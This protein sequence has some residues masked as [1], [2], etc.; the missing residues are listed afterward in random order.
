MTSSQP[1]QFDPQPIMRRAI[2]LAKKAQFQTDP[3]PM[4]GAILVDQSGT[5]LAE[6]YH[7]KA[8]S[9]HAEVETLKSFKKTPKGSV[10]FV[11]LEPCNI[12]GKTPPC[13]DLILDKQV[14]TVIVGCKDPNPKVAGRGIQKL[15]E[16]GVEVIVGVCEQEC[17][18]MNRVFNKHIVKKLPYVTIK[19]AMSL[20]GKIAMASGES[21]WITGCEARKDGQRLRSQHMA[22]AVGNK[23][24]FADNPRLTDRVSESPRQPARVVFSSKGNIPSDSHFL[25]RTETQRIVI[26]GANIAPEVRTQLQQA[27]V[28]LIVENNEFP[29]IPSSLAELYN[30]G[31]CSLLVEGGA[32][33]ISSFINAGMVDCFQIYVAGKIIGDDDAPAWSGNS[34]IRSLAEVPSLTFEKVD[35]IGDD[36]K[37][38]G[39]LA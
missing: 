8:G 18:D 37:I 9:P 22:M 27:G 17:Q 4:V 19:A 14:K 16:Q 39:F 6:G 12:F 10:L 33:L 26:A 35:K 38:T 3:N 23:T 1:F 7:R 31:I 30:L 32:Q 21:Q 28:T 13:T 34:N 15:R 29:E 20:D 25:N 24:L 5:P 36:L 2:G 11:T